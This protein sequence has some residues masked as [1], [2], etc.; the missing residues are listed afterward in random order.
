MLDMVMDE[1]NKKYFITDI[2]VRD[3]KIIITRADESV[4]EEPYS[5][6]N[7]GFYRMQM[8]R[9]AKENINPYMDDLGKDSFLTF[10]KRY[11]AIIGGVASLYFLYNFDI[12]IAMKIIITVLAVLG[13]VG[14]YLYNELY[15]NIVGNEV[16]ECLAT[17]YYIDNLNIFSYYDKEHYTDGFIIPPEDIGKYGLTKDM[18]EQLATGIKEARDNGSEPEHMKLTYKKQDTPKNMV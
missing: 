14:Y 2:E 17:E 11:T 18:L 10:V 1:K 15:L 7:L 8:V 16:L 3:G 13:E 4:T 12:H 5:G 6:H 9:N